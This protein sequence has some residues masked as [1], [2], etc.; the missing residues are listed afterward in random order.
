MR[1]YMGK[2]DFSLQP[3]QYG[4]GW[5]KKTDIWGSFNKPVPV[6]TWET[7]PKLNLYIRPLRKRPSIAFLHKSAK[8][9]IPQFADFDIET[10]ASLRAITPPG[11]AKAFFKANP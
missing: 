3:Y 11:F 8:A 5:T 7:C 4:D 9:L 6:Y 1:K 10:D 2:P